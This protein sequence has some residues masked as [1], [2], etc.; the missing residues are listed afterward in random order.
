MS[1]DRLIAKAAETAGMTK[2]DVEM[3]WKV[4]QKAV[5]DELKGGG[6]SALL[7]VSFFRV[8][9]GVFVRCVIV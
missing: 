8:P 5:A 1:K 4:L 3:V 6:N 7:D 2:K 9:S